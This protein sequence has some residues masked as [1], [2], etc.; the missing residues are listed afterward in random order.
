[1]LSGDELLA[2]FPVG[3]RVVK[4]RRGHLLFPSGSHA[5]VVVGHGTAG[6]VRGML[7]VL[8]DGSPTADYYP[9][10]Y[11]RP[12]AGAAARKERSG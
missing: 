6:R 5:G 8:R 7:R 12:E 1:V 9:P 2:A 4:T 3:S 10:A 11:W